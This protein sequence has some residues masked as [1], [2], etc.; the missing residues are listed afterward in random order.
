MVREGI[1]RHTKLRMANGFR[2]TV[3]AQLE[4]QELPHLIANLGAVKCS[5]A[6]SASSPG[7][8]RGWFG[9]L[10]AVEYAFD[11]YQRTQETWQWNSRYWEQI[12]LLHLAKYFVSPETNDGLDDL[13]LATQHA[14]HAVAIEHH[15]LPLTTLGKILLVQMNIRGY[16]LTA[17]Y[18]EAYENLSEAIRLEKSWSRKAIQPYISL[19]RGTTDFVLRKGVLSMKQLENIQSMS[20]D[21]ERIFGR[22]EE[23]RD[24]LAGMRQALGG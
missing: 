15:P 18:A 11:F 13:E 7:G 21:A 17:S 9:G 3:H 14:R 4:L 19:F 20:K 24:T 12:A 10:L 1:K 5:Y 23:M 8:G 22:D 6:A 2:K 16:S